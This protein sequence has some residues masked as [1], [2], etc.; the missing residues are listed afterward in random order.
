MEKNFRNEE[1][2]GIYDSHGKKDQISE[3]RHKKKTSRK[4]QRKKIKL[5]PRPYIRINEERHEEKNNTVPWKH[6]GETQD[7]PRE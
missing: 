7:Q 3:E 2:A 1:Q 4:D 5:R 6:S